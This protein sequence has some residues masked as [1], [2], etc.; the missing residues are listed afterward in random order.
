MTTTPSNDTTLA[1]QLPEGAVFEDPLAAPLR[2]GRH[3]PGHG[4]GRAI[5][6]STAGTFAQVQA[7]PG[8]V[9]SSIL[10]VWYKQHLAEGGQPDATME[11]LKSADGA[12]R[13]PVGCNDKGRSRG[14]PLRRVGLVQLG[15]QPDLDPGAH[16]DLRPPKA[17]RVLAGVAKNP[18]ISSLAPLVTGAAR[19]SRW[20]I[21]QAHQLD[22]ALDAVQVAAG[23]CVQRAHEFDGNGA[24][25]G[26]CLLRWPCSGGPAGL[27]GLAV[28]AAMWPD[29]NTRLP[30][31]T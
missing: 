29:R 31:C 10:S 25:R 6:S 14:A 30:V 17:L 15:D 3:R 23:G 12:L 11:A 1:R 5:A 20:S 28:L 9:V 21:D 18:P 19:C 2:A 22:D 16:G 13:R 26:L 7:N 24:C 4:P 8:P 27:P